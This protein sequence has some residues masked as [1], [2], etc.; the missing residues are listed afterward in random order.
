VTDH[1]APTGPTVDQER[2]QFGSAGWDATDEESDP[3][4]RDNLT[5][6]TPE[7]PDDNPAPDPDQ[8]QG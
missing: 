5:E 2:E 8:D 6:K 4:T 3:T 7:I 1:D